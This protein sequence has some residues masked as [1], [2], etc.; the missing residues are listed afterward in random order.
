MVYFEKG[1]VESQGRDEA[2][3]RNTLKPELTDSLSLP[4]LLLAFLGHMV[5]TG[6]LITLA[7]GPSGRGT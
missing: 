3:L 4:S 1:S 5:K 7:S 6:L 2:S